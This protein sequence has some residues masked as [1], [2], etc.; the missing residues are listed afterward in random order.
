MQPSVTRI[1]NAA[2]YYP[3]ITAPMP[4]CDPPLPPDVDAAMNQALAGLVALFANAPPCKP[5]RSRFS[6]GMIEHQLVRKRDGSIAFLP[7][8]GAVIVSKAARCVFGR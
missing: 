3:D 1:W 4:A 5:G 6:P 2:E 8:V 7:S